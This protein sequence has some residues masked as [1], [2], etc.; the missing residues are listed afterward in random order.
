MDS[1][2]S[3]R[4]FNLHRLAPWLIPLLQNLPVG[5][6]LSFRGG[7]EVPTLFGNEVEQGFDDVVFGVSRVFGFSRGEV[8]GMGE[9]YFG[10]LG[11]RTSAEMEATY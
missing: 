6:L 11:T 7:D 10:Q 1:L 9:N 8:Y 4:V 5:R 3:I 2:T